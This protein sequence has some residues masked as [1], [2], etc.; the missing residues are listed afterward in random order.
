LTPRLQG[1]GLVPFLIDWGSTP[2]PAVGGAAGCV[3]IE[4]RAEHPEPT[5]IR[6]LLRALNAD[7]PLSTGAAPA[8]VATLE[9]PRGRVALR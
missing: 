1:D 3:L 8:L 9:T 4:L 6:P 5:V 2:H 7:L